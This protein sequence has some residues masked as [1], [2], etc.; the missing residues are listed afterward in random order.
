MKD[1]IIRILAVIFILMYF[2]AVGFIIWKLGIQ[3]PIEMWNAG[4]YGWA[5]IQALLVWSYAITSGGNRK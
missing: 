4:N 3:L 1:N 5:I 2:W